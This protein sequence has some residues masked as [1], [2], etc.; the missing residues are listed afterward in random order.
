MIRQAILYVQENVPKKVA[1]RVFKPILEYWQNDSVIEWRKLCKFTTS[2]I[3]KTSQVKISLAMLVFAIE[4]DIL[5][6]DYDDKFK[7]DLPKIKK[8][9]K[10][11]NYKAKDLFI[12]KYDCVF[13]QK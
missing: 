2:N 7:K 13:L 6:S 9:L 3:A 1:N 8:I 10:Y 12:E 11:S 4:N 5:K